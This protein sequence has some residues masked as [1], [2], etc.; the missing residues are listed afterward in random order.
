[1]TLFAVLAL[2]LPF[3]IPGWTMALTAVYTAP[4]AATVAI[5]V[6]LSRETTP[7][8]SPSPRAGSR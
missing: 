3:G 6:A 8:D 4:L 7:A 1:M 2:L 5:Y